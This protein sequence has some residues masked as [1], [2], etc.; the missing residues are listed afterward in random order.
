MRT[1]DRGRFAACAMAAALWTFLGLA[2]VIAGI[3]TVG[4]AETLSRLAEH[5]ISLVFVIV[6][7]LIAAR[8]AFMAWRIR[9]T[10]FSS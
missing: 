4:L 7:L 3:E 2:L 9:S 6:P 8:Y 1:S 10:V 5:P